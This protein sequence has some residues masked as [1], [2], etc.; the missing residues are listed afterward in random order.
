MDAMERDMNRGIG[1]K[2]LVYIA[3]DDIPAHAEILI[4]YRRSD[5]MDTLSK[6]ERTEAKAERAEKASSKKAE[7]TAMI[8]DHLDDYLDS[9]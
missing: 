7:V 9:L 8:R 3:V 6:E 2:S 1:V 4:H 5:R